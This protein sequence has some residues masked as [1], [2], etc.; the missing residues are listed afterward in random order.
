[1]IRLNHIDKH[2]E[3]VVALNRVNL[4]IEHGKLVVLIGPSGCGKSTLLRVVNR[5]IE[6][7][8]GQILI[9]GKDA[10]D[11]D[12]VLLRRSIGYVIQSAGLFPHLT[13][14]E[15]VAVVPHLLGWSKARRLDRADEMLA[16]V[17]LDPHKFGNRYPKEL[18]G[19]QQQRVG[20]ARALAADPAVLLMDEPFS[21]VDPITREQLQEELLRIQRD[22]RKTIVF[23]THDID[24]AIRLGDKICLMRDGAVVQYADPDTMLRHPADAFTAQFIGQEPELK[25]LGRHSVGD[26]MRPGT[27]EPSLAGAERVGQ[28]TSARSALSK[29]LGGQPALIVVDASG[30]AVGHVA[31]SDFAALA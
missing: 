6:P 4:E 14:R 18:S 2:Y 1:M 31:L 11:I 15:N 22:V 9:D 13:I 8:G 28:A 19:G 27:P 25:R 23:V 12:P 3:Q 20:I 17:Q 30:A 7:S 10:L 24:E 29:L 26:F 21:A 16:L 5:M